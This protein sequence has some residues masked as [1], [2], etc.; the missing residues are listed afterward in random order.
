MPDHRI[1]RRVLGTRP[2]ALALFW[3]IGGRR[4]VDLDFAGVKSLDIPTLAQIADK[5]DVSIDWLLGR[6]NVMS[7]MEMPEPPEPKAKKTAA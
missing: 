2:A 5:L 1:G 4:A 7:V 3:P 6:S